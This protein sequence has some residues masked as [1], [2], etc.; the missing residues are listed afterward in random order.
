MQIRK[1]NTHGFTLI[2]TMISIAV[3]AIIIGVATPSFVGLIQRNSITSDTNEL[4][5]FLNLARSE[6]VKRNMTVSLDAKAGNWGNGFNVRIDSNSEVLR[7]YTPESNN[8]TPIEQGGLTKISFA[9]SGL[10][11][12]AATPPV[13]RLC[14]E[15]GEEGRSVSVSPSGRISSGLLATC[16]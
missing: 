8:T 5:S 6:A 7:D 9:G 2:E 3:L 14:Q 1:S 16:P 11:S 13:F 15:S 12:G 10:L 4:V